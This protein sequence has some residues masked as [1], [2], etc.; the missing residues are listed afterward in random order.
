MINI[1]PKGRSKKDV[2][3]YKFMRWFVRKNREIINKEIDNRIISLIKF[4]KY[5]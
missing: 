3:V 1:I 4:G 5:D 2:A